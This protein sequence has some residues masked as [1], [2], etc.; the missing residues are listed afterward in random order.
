MGT[1]NQEVSC[2]NRKAL[3]INISSIKHNTK[4]YLGEAN[5]KA[6]HQHDL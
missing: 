4:Q 1:A 3:M 5:A 2:A 6:K